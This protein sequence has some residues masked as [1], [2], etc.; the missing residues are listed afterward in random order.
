MDVVVEVTNF[1]GLTAKWDRS[2]GMLR[3]LHH[4]ASGGCSYKTVVRMQTLADEMQHNS[5]VRQKLPGL[6]N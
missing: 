6:R 2:K 3:I 5:A 1:I 4:P